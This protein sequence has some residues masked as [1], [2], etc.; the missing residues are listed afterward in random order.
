MKRQMSFFRKVRQSSLTG[1]SYS[2]VHACVASLVFVLLAINCGPPP[3]G[4]YHVPES[5]IQAAEKNVPPPQSAQNQVSLPDSATVYLDRVPYVRNAFKQQQQRVGRTGLDDF[6]ARTRG[7]VQHAAVISGGSLDVLKA[8][9]A[10]GW[11]PVVMVQIQGRSPE[12]LLLTHYNERSSEVYLKNPVNSG[13]RR[14][15]YQDFEKYWTASSKN[16]FLLITPQELTETD[17]QNVLGRYLPAA[18]F[19]QTSVLRSR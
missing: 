9:V 4:P 5:A 17:V 6:F 14:L 8:F 1:S 12:I 2:T 19:Q 11:P 10:K 13:E 15:S 7:R 16:R 3:Q 18:A